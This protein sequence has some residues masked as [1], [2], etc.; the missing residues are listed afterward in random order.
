M[1]LSAMRIGGLADAAGVT[2]RWRPFL[3]GPILKTLGWDTSPFKS[4]KEKCRHMVRDME[5]ICAERGLAFTMPETFPQNGLY[6]AR[7]ALVASDEGWVED[8]T[9]AVYIAE[10][11]EGREI[12]D[13]AVLTDCL[14][15]VGRDPDVYFERIAAP[16]IK[17]RLKAQTSEA[18][19]LH[20]FGAPTFITGD[21]ELFWGDD[22]LEQALA[23]A[24]R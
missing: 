4:Q 6:A 11:G 18:A 10:Y 14:K 20:V 8:F 17:D 2:V 15:N 23:W 5:R 19:S 22:R 9:K 13:E 24:V 1:P 3:L 7:I 21:G 12:A 16:E